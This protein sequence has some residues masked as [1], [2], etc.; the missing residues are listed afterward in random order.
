M[1]LPKTPEPASQENS[2]H[3][4]MKLFKWRIKLPEAAKYLIALILG[5]VIGAVILGVSGQCLGCEYQKLPQAIQIPLL[6]I[7]IAGLG[8]AFINALVKKDANPSKILFL[9]LGLLITSFIY[10]LSISTYEGGN[11]ARP[12]CT[13]TLTPAFTPT[14]TRTPT[15]TPTPTIGKQYRIRF[16]VRYIPNDGVQHDV[17]YSVDGGDKQFLF[18]AGDQ[19]DNTFYPTF[20]LS[21]HVG[22]TNIVTGTVLYEA[23]YVNE[24]MVAS[25]DVDNNGLTYQVPF[26]Q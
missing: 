14:L 11:Y 4:L 15:V 21:I 18:T 24:K 12:Q 1:T 3:G 17:Y 25:S 19:F 6:F 16:V 8:I 7:V 23:L 20:S 22:I 26:K 5:G 10:L 9:M 2:P 13:L